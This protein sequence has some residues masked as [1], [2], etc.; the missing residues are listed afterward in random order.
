MFHL[1]VGFILSYVAINVSK[2]EEREPEASAS[3][4]TSVVEEKDSTGAHDFYSKKTKAEI[5]FLKRKEKVVSGVT[6]L[7]SGDWCLI[8]IFHSLV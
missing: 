2:H 8:E 4:S 1:K 3:G 5:A 7:V 6:P